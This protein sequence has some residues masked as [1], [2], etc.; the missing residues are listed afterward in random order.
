MIKCHSLTLSCKLRF[1]R[2]SARLRF[3]NRAECGNNL[4]LILNRSFNF[5]PPC[6]AFDPELDILLNIYCTAA[7]QLYITTWEQREELISQ[8]A[9]TVTVSGPDS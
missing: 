8:G 5:A 4:N 3:Q 1:A 2:I 7:C 9:E 6:I